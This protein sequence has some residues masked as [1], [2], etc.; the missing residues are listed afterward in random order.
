M[1]K[2]VVLINSEDQQF[3]GLRTSLGLLMYN[4]EVRMFVIGHEVLKT[5]ETYLDHLEFLDEMEG[6]RFSDNTVNVEKFGFKHSTVE[7]M[8]SMVK[9]ADLVIPY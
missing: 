7:Q 6:E 1:R 3:E 8:A 5:N 4:A 2:V 9:E